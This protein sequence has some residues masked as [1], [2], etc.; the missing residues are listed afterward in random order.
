MG[1]AEKIG[2]AGLEVLSRGSEEIYFSAVSIWELA[3]KVK[4]GKFKL[5]E[6]PGPYV[7]SLLAMQGICP[8]AITQ[9]H[10]LKVYDLPLDRLLIAQALL[11]AMVILTPDRALRR[12]PAELVWRG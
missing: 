12:Y 1:P 4:L 2:R 10:G 11:E 8:L 6:A 5:P 7:R 3:I 9:D